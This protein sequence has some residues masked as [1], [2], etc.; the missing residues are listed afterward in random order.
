MRLVLPSSPAE[1]QEFAD[2]LA[3]QH[4]VEKWIGSGPF[5]GYGLKNGDEIVAAVVL[6]PFHSQGSYLASMSIDSPDVLK[7]R[8][9]TK[10]VLSVPF[11]KLFDANRV[12]LIIEDRYTRIIRVAEILGFKVDGELPNHFGENSGILLG[13]TKD[14]LGLVA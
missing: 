8:E 7:N 1:S 10:H 9:L 12:S 11:S 5:F 6:E 4:G 14:P 2:W 13:M 3:Q